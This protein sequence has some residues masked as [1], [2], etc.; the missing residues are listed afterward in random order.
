MIQAFY[1]SKP[2]QDTPYRELVLAHDEGKGWHVLLLGGTE[3]GKGKSTVLRD[4]S[5][6]DF[7]EGSIVYDNIYEELM[8]ASW[9]PY[10]PYETWD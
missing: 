4:E 9:K 3:W 7:D 10:A 2:V 6:K 5:V 1:Q 8:A